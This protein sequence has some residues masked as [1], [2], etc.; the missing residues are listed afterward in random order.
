MPTPTGPISIR[1]SGQKSAGTPA[2]AALRAA[3]RDGT[4]LADPFV[5]P[6][7]VKVEE[8]YGVVPAARATAPPVAAQ[9]A[10]ERLVALET[11]DGTTVFL[12]A[13]KL[14]ADV[15]RLHPEAIVDGTIDLARLRDR[16]S[17]SRGLLDVLWTKVSFLNLVP[18]A[19][20]DK[21]RE[22]AIELIKEAVGD[23]IADTITDIAE[24]SVSWWGAKALMWAIESQL[25]GEPGLYRWDGGEIALTDRVRTSDDA[26]LVEAAKTGRIL[27]FIHGTGSHTRG[28]FGQLP[29][30]GGG[31]EWSELKKVFGERIFGFE[32]RTFSE[33]PIENALQLVR[34]LPAGA[35]LS[36]VTHSRGGLVGDL[37][38]LGDIDEELIRAYQ[39]P[40][41]REDETELDRKVRL[42]VIRRE[43]DLLRELRVALAE[44]NFQIE[45][46]VRVACPA[47]GTRLLSDN[48]DVFL[49]GLLS[50]TN[51]AVGAITGPA[52][53]PVL[54]A[55]KRVVL[56][57]A[58]K[59]IDP[60][61]VP[62][63][64][65]MHVGSPLGRLLLRAP[66]KQGVAMAVIAGDIEGGNLL[67][68][69]GV[70]FTDWMLFD[71]VD[72]DLVV[73]TGSMYGGLATRPGARALFDAGPEVDH[74]SYFRN[75]LTRGA[76][77]RWLTSATTDDLGDF[78][79]MEELR[80]PT[81]DEVESAAQSRSRSRGDEP[82]TKPI[83]I[84]LPGIMGSHLAVGATGKADRVWFNPL[85]IALGGMN[86]L[87]FSAPEVSPDGL[88]EMFY[89]DLARHL[90]TTHEVVRFPYDWR[91]PIAQT[92]QLLANEVEKALARTAQPIRLLA[93]SMGGLVCRQ[94]IQTRDDLWKAITSRPGARFVMLGTPNNGSHAMVETLLGKSDSIRKLAVA[95]QRH[96]MRELLDIVAGF[97]G[98][99]AL[100]PRPDFDDGGGSDKYFDPARWRTLREKNEDFWFGDHHGGNAS[101]E[102]LDRT[103][104]WWNALPDEAPE[105]VSCVAYVF[106]RDRSTPCGIQVPDEAKRDLPPTKRLK[107]LGTP[108]GDGTVTWRSGRLSNLPDDRY[109]LMPVA[110]GDL[111]DTAEYFPAIT[112]LL[113]GGT[114]TRLEQPPTR[115][116]ASEVV[117]APYDAAP[118]LVATEADLARSIMGG[119]PKRRVRVKRSQLEVS[120]SAMDLCFAQQPVMCG[121]YVGDAISGAE[122]LI[123]RE[124][125]NGE[126]TRRDTLGIYPSELASNAIVLNRR[127]E[128]EI[129]RGTGRGAV[130]IGLGEYGKLSARQ[131]TDTVRAGVVRLLLFWKDH[132]TGGATG[133]NELRL[134]SLLLGHNSTTHIS[135]QASVDAVVQG[136]C[137]ANRQFEEA[138][139]SEQGCARVA[140]LEFVELYLDTAISAAREIRTLPERL[141]KEL[142]R[143]RVTVAP[144]AELNVGTGA[145]PR[146]AEPRQNGY[147]AR[148]IVTDADRDDDT[149]SS[150]C[151]DVRLVS[152]IPEETIRTIAARYAASACKQGGATSGA[153]GTATEP[154]PAAPLAID[155]PQTAPVA[156]RLK[157]VFL[158][159]RARAETTV[160]QRQPGLVEG[161]VKSAIRSG[162]YDGAT[163]HT[164]FQHLLPVDFRSVVR[165]ASN[166]VLVVDGYTANL[167]WEMVSVDGR[168]L[169]IDVGIVRQLS[170]SQGRSTVR[171]AVA[172]KACIIANP[173]TDG[174][175]TAFP[176]GRAHATTSLD[177]LSGAETEGQKVLEVL[178]RT[179]KV[180][181]AP[182]G[183]QALDVHN[184]L[185]ADAYR[186]LVIAAHGVV[187]V[188]H[189]DGSRRTGVVLSDGLLLTAA[190][191]CLME[192]VPQVVFLNC[193]HSGKIDQPRNS[194]R[195]AHSLA[196]ELIEIG[197][198]CVVAAGWPVDDAAA[199]AFAATFF[200]TLVSRGRPFGEA[201]LEAR[202][203]C[204]EKAPDLNTWGAYQAYGDPTFVLEPGAATDAPAGRG[205]D[206]VCADEAVDRLRQLAT[207][208]GGGGRPPL[209]KTVADIDRL[210][211]RAPVA[212]LDLPV[213]QYELGG[214]YGAY[215]QEGFERATHAYLR[216]IAEEDR[217]GRVPITAIEQLA[218]LEARIGE[219]KG[220]NEGL[221]LVSAAIERFR[222]LL[223]LGATTEPATA[224]SRESSERWALLGSALKRK[225]VLQARRR[226]A[227]WSAVEKTLQEA[228]DAYARAAAPRIDGQVSPYAVLNQLHLDAVLGVAKADHARLVALA[229]RAAAAA[230]EAFRRSGRYFDAVG[231]ADAELAKKLIVGVSDDDVDALASVFRGAISQV[232]TS[233]RELDSTIKQFHLLAEFLALRNEPRARALINALKE[234]ADRLR[235]TFA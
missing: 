183:S 224:S 38:C 176:D 17:T 135:V 14:Y 118:P 197:V 170:S 42:D 215:G 16:Q 145:R 75:S 110:H 181:Y 204:Y 51:T 182:P 19:I 171:N 201:V 30:A 225:A 139:G 196:R 130:I 208:C 193:C 184:K 233:E 125:V 29:A 66:R 64:E 221:K 180:T 63:I 131:L 122:A 163:A 20:V 232:P 98:A 141:E 73:D 107:M 82:G 235:T 44:K 133:A 18:D 138:M 219:A 71:R 164:L 84:L 194:N 102:N 223:A 113:T 213:V 22:K 45:R 5:G 178:Q 210:L 52:G 234:L 79:A 166:L 155:R 157:Y 188:V 228:R 106:G 8:V 25:A 55:F 128:E 43:Q 220:G 114:T 153:D 111:A 209:K 137:E 192:V 147:W 198:R 129:R 195:L 2:P 119:R 134:M 81:V 37:L 21:A 109:R 199:V 72:N 49:S 85:R 47:Q 57:I 4:T 67:K 101:A 93:H 90:E 35:R 40:P 86:D 120:V 212:W 190:E 95:D 159:E 167:P 151:Y 58:H 200:E 169:A 65:A 207:T 206:F 143:L 87:A 74:F 99:L 32:H 48:L 70:L 34:T 174:F 117:A 132:R 61:L 6:Q 23:A 3:A 211:T 91:Q 123:D 222:G 96:D 185:L 92:A 203:A 172:R 124:L 10:A 77:T 46:Y 205:S 158:S 226:N 104:D 112:E 144:A 189:R 80:E 150:D 142:A 31:P 175:W 161:L 41:L 53:S 59:R 146:L 103:R 62:G 127:D 148:L 78:A 115:R 156:T 89:G 11:A 60:R 83:V 68:R 202:R 152:R 230:R 162:A 7:A 50:L 187:D 179:H 97:P 173:S 28:G 227:R 88:F 168:P 231:P 56:E 24:P 116:D 13:D 165:Q 105:P 186:I 160:L 39:R 136:V 15:A 94:M 218:N 12:R 54:S 121:H 27:L 126:L 154:T 217:L 229:D 214:L 33:S 36:L 191:V 69:I 1:F 149:C 9:A 26:R 177:S 76:M 108:D 140:H 100:L 216:A